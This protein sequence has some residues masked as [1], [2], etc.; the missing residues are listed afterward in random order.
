MIISFQFDRDR[1]ED[2]LEVDL[3]DAFSS[4]FDFG[5][6]VLAQ[7]ASNA[8]VKHKYV[9]N[10]KDVLPQHPV[11]IYLYTGS[12][13]SQDKMLVIPMLDSDVSLRPSIQAVTRYGYTSDENIEPDAPQ[14]RT[15]MWGN[16]A[17]VA[18]GP[19][20]TVRKYKPEWTPEI[21]LRLLV[22]NELA[23]YAGQV[24]GTSSNLQV[25]EA[26]DQMVEYLFR[27]YNV[28]LDSNQIDQN[29]KK[30][31]FSTLCEIYAS[32]SLPGA[33][34]KYSVDEINQLVMQTIREYNLRHH[35]PDAVAQI[36]QQ[37][38]WNIIRDPGFDV[39]GYLKRCVGLG[40][41]TK[42]EANSPSFSV[43]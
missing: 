26:Y 42:E 10:L 33:Q 40:L 13:I 27:L 24:M 8:G 16:L 1:W 12:L 43:Y 22:T 23:G 30:E 38:H 20:I 9:F 21:R 34:G 35:N 2:V 41:L 15:V 36:G 18:G 37:I 32:A 25:K 11:Y 3:K 4:A 19:E 5:S 31:I 6:E 29:L 14:F 17:Y 39:K 28:N 7:V